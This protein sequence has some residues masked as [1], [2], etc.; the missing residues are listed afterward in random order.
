MTEYTPGSVIA[1]VLGDIKYGRSLAK[2]HAVQGTQPH[3]SGLTAIA[4]AHWS[5]ID[6]LPANLRGSAA[7][8]ENIHAPRVSVTADAVTL[9][10]ELSNHMMSVAHEVNSFL[11]VNLFAATDFTYINKEMLS[12]Y[13]NMDTKS[14]STIEKNVNT[15]GSFGADYTIDTAAIADN[16]PETRSKSTQSISSRVGKLFKSCF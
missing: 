9:V 15:T 2:E 10:H 14:T 8:T 13:F 5:R 4:V 1:A 11:D 12:F 3:R 7:A 6:D 16:E